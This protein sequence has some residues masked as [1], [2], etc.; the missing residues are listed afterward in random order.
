M[1]DLQLVLLDGGLLTLV[2][3]VFIGATIWWKPRLWL[4]DFPPDLRAALP[5]KTAEERRLTA[6]VATPWFIVLF[7]GLGATAAR[8]GTAHGYPAM[9]LHVYLVW[10]MFNLFD[11]LVIDWLGMH[12]VDPDDPP[13]EGTAGLAGYR[14]YRFHAVGFAKGS[15]MGLGVAAVIAGVVWWWLP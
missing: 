6:L 9:A 13:F 3:A 11:L 10:L 7:G 15:V 14:D 5:P 4:Q 8:F 2:S 1:I 12:L